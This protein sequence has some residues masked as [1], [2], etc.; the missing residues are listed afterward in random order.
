MSQDKFRWVDVKGRGKERIKRSG[1]AMVWL[2]VKG[3]WEMMRLCL[4][5]RNKERERGEAE[6]REYKHRSANWF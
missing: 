2:R 6:G 3:K 1:E 5:N 4:L